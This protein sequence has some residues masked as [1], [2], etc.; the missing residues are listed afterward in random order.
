MFTVFHPLYHVCADHRCSSTTRSYGTLYTSAMYIII[1]DTNKKNVGLCTMDRSV[2][3][4]P[5]HYSFSITHSVLLSLFLSLNRLYVL[6]DFT[7]IRKKFRVCVCKV[8]P[9]LNSR[10]IKLIERC[11][12]NSRRQVHLF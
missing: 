11:S 4:P 5:H 10:R 3:Y 6:L 9:K 2:V 8:C 12:T 1:I 7:F